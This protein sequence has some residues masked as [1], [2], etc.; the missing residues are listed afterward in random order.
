MSEKSS[1]REKQLITENKKLKNDLLNLKSDRWIEFWDSFISNFM[2]YSCYILIAYFTSKTLIEYAGKYSYANLNFEG[3]VS[4]NEAGEVGQQCSYPLLFYVLI[5]INMLALAAVFG[6]AK[7]RERLQ[8][9]TIRQLA[10]AKI[11]R[12]KDIDPKRSSSGLK[13]EG[14]KAEE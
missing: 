10:P 3:S 12:E 7:G 1:R 13:D 2:R 8:R 6:F 5:I 11:N 14:A 9:A 4:L